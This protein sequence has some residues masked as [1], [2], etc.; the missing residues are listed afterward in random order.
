MSYNVYESITHSEL[1][2][3]LALVKIVL[4]GVNLPLVLVT[5]CTVDLSALGKLE[6]SFVQKDLCAVV[7]P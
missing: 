1:F 5:I 2:E 3:L 7:G 4:L 6:N